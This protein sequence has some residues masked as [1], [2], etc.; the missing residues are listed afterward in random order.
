MQIIRYYLNASGDTIRIDSISIDIGLPPPVMDPRLGTDKGLMMS[1]GPQSVKV[2]RVYASF[3]SRV[4]DSVQ[5]VGDIDDIEPS[6]G[7]FTW[8]SKTLGNDQVVFFDMSNLPVI[9]DTV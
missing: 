1:L 4:V 6:S 5:V 7:S 2:E 8:A 3:A 9:G